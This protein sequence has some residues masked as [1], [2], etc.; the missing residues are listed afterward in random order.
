[1]LWEKEKKKENIQP[2]Q[3]KGKGRAA[4]VETE[5][6]DETLIPIPPPSQRSSIEIRSVFQPIIKKPRQYFTP[7]RYKLPPPKTETRSTPVSPIHTGLFASSKSSKLPDSPHP[8][9]PLEF[10]DKM[11]GHAMLSHVVAG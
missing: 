9:I 2:K 10:I 6:E 3:N 1:M 4:I 7:P 5:E 8:E 11:V